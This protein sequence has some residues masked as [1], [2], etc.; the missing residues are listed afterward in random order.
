MRTFL[1]CAS[2]L[3]AAML[4]IVGTA[5][6]EDIIVPES[7]AGVWETTSTERDCETLE[8]INVTTTL[9]TLCA[10]DIMN[11]QDPDGE[12]P[13][14][15]CN[16]TVTDGAVHMECSVTVEIMPG[17]TL[18]ISFVSDGTMD[19]D[20]S[21]GVSINTFTYTGA[22]CFFP[23]TCTR[24]ETTSVRTGDDP[25]CGLTPVDSPSWGTLKSSFR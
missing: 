10:G 9:D 5:S 22:A 25:G 15:D 2:S 24:F 19:G 13:D 11:P 7:W 12:M 23:D 17:C 4:V 1:S 3:I 14:F 18:T 6:A 21:S 16:G 20:T 8:I